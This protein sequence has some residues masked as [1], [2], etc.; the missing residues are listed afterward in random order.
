MKTIMHNGRDIKVTAEAERA[1]RMLAHRGYAAKRGEF[2]EKAGARGWRY[3]KFTLPSI[4][5]SWSGVYEVSKGRAKTAREKAFFA[6]HPRCLTGIFGDV[7]R[8]NSII[9]KLEG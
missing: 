2:T 9:K 3:D 6:A 5:T 8:I 7:R 4:L 1:L